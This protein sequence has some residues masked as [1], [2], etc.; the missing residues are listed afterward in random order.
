MI[1]TRARRMVH[2]L[3]KVHKSMD[4]LRRA[5]NSLLRSHLPADRQLGATLYVLQ[6]TGMRIGWPKY[7]RENGTFGLSTLTQRHIVCTGQSVAIEF[8]GKAG[9]CN[10]FKIADPRVRAWLC[11][12]RAAGVQPF[13]SARTVSKFLED[14][15]GTR[16]KDY[17]T[18]VANRM[19][20][21]NRAKGM[22]DQQSLQAVAASLHHTPAVC[23]KHYLHPSLLGRSFV[24]SD[25]RKIRHQLKNLCT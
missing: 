9:V 20:L 1:R 13:A 14:R 22:G 4:A 17:R 16:P 15:F 25:K 21:D 7:L 19:F 12:G 10:R 5:T 6:R 23:K 8:R 2:N 24:P 18:W 11:E 3:C